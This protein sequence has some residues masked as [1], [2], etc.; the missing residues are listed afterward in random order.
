MQ[1]VLHARNHQ[2][3][4]PVGGVVYSALAVKSFGATAAIALSVL[5]SVGCGTTDSASV[6]RPPE[7]PVGIDAGFYLPPDDGAVVGTPT[8]ATDDSLGDTTDGYSAGALPIV[9]VHG[10]AGFSQI[11]PVDYF[12]QVAEDLR[13]H[14]ETVFT[15]EVSPFLPPERRAPMLGAYIDGVLGE[16]H[17]PRVDIIAHSQGGMDARYLISTLHYGDRVAALVTVATPHRGTRVADLFLGYVQGDPSVVN[18]L[19]TVLGLTYNQAGSEADVHATLAGLSERAAPVFNAANPDDPRVLYW[20]YAGRSNGRNGALE[21]MNAVL[22]N[23]VGQRDIPNLLLQPTVNYL[24]QGDP[25]HHVNDGMVEVQS[26]RWGV[27]MGCEPADHF[28]EVGQILRFGPDP[29]SGFDHL[30]FYRDIVARLH[31]TGL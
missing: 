21:C 19:A 5:P 8:D 16:T 9:L 24:E 22:P 25:V 20:S 6:G 30:T 12:F 7:D 14:G 23:A 31:R 18:A 10:F 1:T 27:F 17:A 13:S 3:E 26:A 28:A 15:C 4:V 11:G 29:V 2:P